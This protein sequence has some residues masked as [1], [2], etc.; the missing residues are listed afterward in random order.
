[1]KSPVSHLTILAFLALVHPASAVVNIE[2]MGVGNAGNAADTILLDISLPDINGSK[3]LKSLRSDPATAH[4]PVIPIGA[5]AMSRDIEMGL[6][7]GFFRYLT[8][9]IRIHK[10]MVTLTVALWHEEGDQP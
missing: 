2:W 5:N 7:A 10:L 3:V 9:P 1:M 4:I 8:K 6:K